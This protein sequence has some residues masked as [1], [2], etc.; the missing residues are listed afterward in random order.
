MPAY[1][2]RSHLIAKS[3][4]DSGAVDPTVPTRLRP[5]V[6]FPIDEWS[7]KPDYD[8][9]SLSFRYD[10]T[11]GQGTNSQKIVASHPHIAP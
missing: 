6:D 5:G 2:S 4:F 8:A 1:T 11:R 3:A 9:I 7:G 10:Q